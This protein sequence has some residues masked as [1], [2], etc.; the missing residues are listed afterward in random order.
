MTFI[1]IITT[2]NWVLIAIYGGFVVW[3]LMQETKPSHELGNIESQMQVV[4][5]LM[6][7]VVAGLNAG[8]HQWMKILAT[9]IVSLLLLIIQQ[10]ATN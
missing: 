7:L 10:L 4:M 2:I 5:F 9:V 8:S 1:K 3:A 6:L